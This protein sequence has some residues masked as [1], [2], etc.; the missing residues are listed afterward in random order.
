[1]A[2]RDHDAC[3]RPDPRRPPDTGR[4]GR[5]PR[6]PARRTSKDIRRPR[7]GRISPH[8][9]AAA[10]PGASRT[11]ATT[12]HEWSQP[13][14][15]GD[16][17]RSPPSAD[18]LISATASPAHRVAKPRRLRVHGGRSC[19]ASSIRSTPQLAAAEMTRCSTHCCFTCTLKLRVA[20]AERSPCAW[21]T[22][23]SSSASSG[24]MRKAE[25]SAGSRSA[26]CSP[27]ASPTMLH[28]LAG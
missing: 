16:S 4:A 6:R 23:T 20:A 26:R 19:R 12:G 24:W 11:Y 18:G 5:Y 13:G 8:V 7:S 25:H 17:T 22:S 27:D 1:V 9:I 15:T 2:R 3:P 21:R 10:G 14:A 28:D